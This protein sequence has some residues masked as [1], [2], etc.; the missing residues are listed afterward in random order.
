[1]FVLPGISLEALLGVDIER[2]GW[3]TGRRK[4]TKLEEGIQD[5]VWFFLLYN[6]LLFL[7]FIG[8]MENLAQTF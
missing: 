5:M 1:M 4:D 7:Q 2:E 3:L 8:S 6:M